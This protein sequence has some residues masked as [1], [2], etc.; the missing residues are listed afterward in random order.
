[1]SEALEALLAQSRSPGALLGR[2]RFSLAHE[3]AADWVRRGGLRHPDT[4]VLELIR[5]A[6]WSGAGWIAVEASAAHTAVAWVGGR[7]LDPDQLGSLF[8]HLLSDPRDPADRSLGQLARGIAGGLQR[9]ATGITVDAGHAGGALRLEVEVGGEAQLARREVGL[10]GTVV[11][12]QWRRPPWWRRWL[13][14][15]QA[16]EPTEEEVLIEERCAHLPVPL[17]LN[18]RAPF[19]WTPSP[20]IQ[21]PG[22]SPQRRLRHGAVHGVIGL[23]PEGLSARPGFELLIGGVGLGVFP[24]AELGALPPALRDARS[25]AGVGGVVSN[26]LLLRT[27]DQAELVQESEYVNLLH[28]LQGELEGLVRGLPGGE[29]WRGPLL[30]PRAQAGAAPLPP[31]LAQLGG[32]PPVELRALAATPQL[33]VLR[34]DPAHASAVGPAAPPDRVPYPVLVLP[35]GAAPALDAA[36]GRTAL[37]LRGPEDVPAALAQLDAGAPPWT[38]R[39]RHAGPGGVPGDPRAALDRACTA[40]VRPGAPAPGFGGGGALVLISG[41]E[42]IQVGPAGPRLCLRMEPPAEALSSPGL[43]ERL[44]LQLPALLADPEAPP[45]LRAELAIALLRW[46][47]WPSADPAQP[48]LPPAWEVHREVILEAPLSWTPDGRPIAAR[49]ALRGAAPGAPPPGG[50]VADLLAHLSARAATGPPLPPPRDLRGLRTPDTPDLC[51]WAAEGPGLAL[52]WAADGPELHGVDAPV[53]IAA[54]RGPSLAAAA[55]IRALHEALAS[56]AAAP[57]AGPGPLLPELRSLTRAL[58]PDGELPV[59]GVP[60]PSSA[61]AR[62]TRRQGRPLMEIFVDHPAAQAAAAG[63]PRA[64]LGV[65][66]LVLGELHGR[67]AALPELPDGNELHARLIRWRSPAAD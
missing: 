23:I 2:R 19:G 57:P 11:R 36:L 62:L 52:L 50:A 38:A 61:A 4:Y 15:G 29:G 26:D 22:L 10:Q 54:A 1:V 18:G 39:L 60:G 55:A 31:V 3:R 24:L 53:F 16:E 25:G 13:A 37:P 17:L 8:G 5:A 40:L 32:R 20:E 43:A 27:P 44:W 30:P 59:V 65:Q 33:P 7:E 46:G 66:L 42:A 21:A 48:H 56:P 41:E 58:W 63:D 6:V 49:A 35:E 34:V 9:G 67:R 51:A 28:A 14:V 47:A 64:R 12:L 45:G